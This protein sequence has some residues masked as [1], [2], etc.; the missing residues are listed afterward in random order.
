LGRNRDP[1]PAGPFLPHPPPPHSVFTWSP[2]TAQPTPFH[3]FSRSL[4][5]ARQPG[6][7]ARLAPPFISYYVAQ[8]RPV[9]SA[10]HVIIVSPMETAPKNQS[11]SSP[12][13]GFSLNQ[14]RM[15]PRSNPTLLRDRVTAEHDKEPKSPIKRAA[16]CRIFA[17]IQAQTLEAPVVPS[18]HHCRPS[19]VEPVPRQQSTTSTALA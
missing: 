4:P 9:A 13:E 19:P 15:N 14:I 1:S 8:V 16:S 11:S 3:Y 5:R 10:K 6:Q 12:R 18:S 17:Q 2:A 7:L